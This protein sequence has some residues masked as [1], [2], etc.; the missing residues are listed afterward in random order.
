MG[1][2]LVQAAMEA[3]A[4]VA[5]ALF[6][7]AVRNNDVAAQIFWLKTRARWHTTEI[8]QHQ[9]SVSGSPS[10]NITVNVY[11]LERQKILNEF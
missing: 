9:G 3:N 8:H 7:N 2:E 10:Q 1:P 4:K 5:G 11:K 6:N